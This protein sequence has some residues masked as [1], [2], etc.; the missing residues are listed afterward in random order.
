MS[1]EPDH[2]FQEQKPPISISRLDYERLLNLANSVVDRS[3]DIAEEL[4]NELYR[5]D[6]VDN[7][8]E[9]F[10]QMGSVVEYRAEDGQTRRVE[11]VYPGK[12]DIALG[13]ISVLT[14]IGTAL[15]GLSAEQS[16]DWTS[17]DGRRHIL[18]IVTVENAPSSENG[19]D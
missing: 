8:L 16:I 15:I 10:I 9:N 12:A 19:S 17:L 6:V 18:T 11:L 3:P 4:L 5:A 13:K 7:G 14:P 2:S 1:I